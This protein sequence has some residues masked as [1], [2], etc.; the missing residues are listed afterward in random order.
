MEKILTIVIP[1]YNMQDYLRRCLNSLIVPEEQM[2]HLEVLVVNDGSKDNSS[3][4]AHEYQDKYPGTFRVI[5]KDNGNYGSCVNRG[6]KEATGKY[7]RILDAD[8][9][10]DN[11]ELEKFVQSL[12]YIPS[13]DVVFT[14]YTIVKSASKRKTVL[15][16][17]L[18]YNVM[19]RTEIL[20]LKK[21]ADMLRMH[22]MTYRTSLLREICLSL[23]TGIS[24][25]DI[26]YCYFPYKATQTC[27]ALDINL[28]H[29]WTARDG[30]TM[31]P[32]SIVKK[33]DD[34]YAVSSRIIKDFVTNADKMS[35]S[36]QETLV[37]ILRNPLYFLFLI[38]LVLLK[39]VPNTQKHKLEKLKCLY[40]NCKL[41][42]SEVTSF[43]YRKIPF[44]KLYAF[45]PFKLSCIFGIR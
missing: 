13:A 4:I 43:T 11:V 30:Q 33:F 25:T 23:Q 32:K 26:E 35:I 24:Y 34:F 15:P 38:N 7:F 9:W 17:V 6:L 10:F 1:T 18:K 20:S 39:D 28:Y 12:N 2:Q 37:K 3:A 29:Y 42:S 40:Q 44:V 36:K 16:R 45:L 8:D 27:I 41:I 19:Q 14:N 5:D 21:D 22:S 31:S